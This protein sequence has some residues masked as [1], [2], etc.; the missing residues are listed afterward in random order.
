MKRKI[1]KYLYDIITSIDSIY[2][3]LGPERNF[4]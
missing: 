1:H 4:F 3:Y 2:A